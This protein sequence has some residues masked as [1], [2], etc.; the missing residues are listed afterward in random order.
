MKNVTMNSQKGFS[1]VE[2]MVVVSI[3]GILAAIAIP[4]FQRFS[5]KAKQ[6]EAKANLAA[7]YSAERSFLSEWNI[8]A[9]G[10]NEIGYRPSGWVRYNH[11]FGAA[12]A[13][14]PTG[15]IKAALDNTVINS[16][17]ACPAGGVAIGATGCGTI[18]TPTAPNAVAGTN[19]VAGG[20]TT[21]LAGAVASLGGAN[22]DTWT[23]NQ[24]K[25]IKNTSTNSLP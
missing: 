4:N 5:A 22:Q 14:I 2:L 24:N 15:Y 9:T 16:L 17:A 13:T 21:F 23:I 3:I 10:F 11:G 12:F 8:F 6:A 1:L 20:G 18:N 25:D 19:I 7:L